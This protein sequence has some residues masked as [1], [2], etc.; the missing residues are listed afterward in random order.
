GKANVGDVVA[1]VNYAARIAMSISMLT[2]IML[3]ISRMQASAKR[4]S[5]VLSIEDI[6]EID[7]LYNEN[8]PK[9]KRGSIKFNNVTFSYPYTEKQIL[10]NINFSINHNETIAIIGSTGAGKTTLFHL[11]AQL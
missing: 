3:N 6:E 9:I 8:N 10:K 5:D 7:E 4:L 2:F 11:I 1:I